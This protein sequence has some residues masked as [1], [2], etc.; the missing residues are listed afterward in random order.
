MTG[1][2]R[3]LFREA[4]LRRYAA[5]GMREESLRIVSPRLLV[6]L[7]TFTGL[8]GCGL[9]VLAAFVASLIR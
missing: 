4:V 3:A 2:P 6:L 8:L 5:G 7:W 1:R 9:L